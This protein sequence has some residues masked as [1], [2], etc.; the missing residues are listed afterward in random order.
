MMNWD[1][2]ENEQKWWKLLKRRFAL[3]DGLWWNIQSNAIYKTQIPNSNP[4]GHNDRSFI[5]IGGA[6]KERRRR[7]S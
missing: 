5:F 7:R 2:D 4:N 3:K 6:T 1:L